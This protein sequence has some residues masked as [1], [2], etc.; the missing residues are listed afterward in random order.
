VKRR[1]ARE[2]RPLD[3]NDVVPAEP[4]EPVEDRA[5]ADAASDHDCP[6]TILHLSEPNVEGPDAS[7]DQ[8]LGDLRKLR[9]IRSAM[10]LIGVA[11]FA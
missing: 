5:A 3:E 9:A 10:A 7:A 11:R 4:R 6:G 2:L 1:S 8:T